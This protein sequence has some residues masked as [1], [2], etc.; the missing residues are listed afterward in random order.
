M[1]QLAVKPESRAMR[2]A[3]EY[4]LPVVEKRYIRKSIQNIEDAMLVSKDKV[5]SMPHVD[6]FADGL[7]GR[8]LF[9]PAGIIVTSMIHVKDHF[10]FVMYG[11]AEVVDEFSGA[12]L[13]TGP[14]MMK[15]KA[16][17]KRILRIL[18]DS[19]WITVHATEETDVDEIVKSVTS[20]THLDDLG[21]GK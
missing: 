1:S 20:K 16:G 18:E 10:C 21:E 14:C 13:V 7:Y 8:E 17:T 11:K 12:Q 9:M 19:L 4:A 6:H 2:P 15:T 5:E 3:L